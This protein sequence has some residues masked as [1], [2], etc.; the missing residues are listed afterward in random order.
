[1]HSANLSY[2][3]V[4]TSHVSR[5]QVMTVGLLGLELIDITLDP[6][7]NVSKCLMQIFLYKPLKH[8]VALFVTI[9]NNDISCKRSILCFVLMIE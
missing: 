7:S 3:K 9:Y 5:E 4:H 6:V 2:C 8:S 1:M